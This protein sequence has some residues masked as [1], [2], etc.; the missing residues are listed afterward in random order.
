MPCTCR[1]VATPGR[2]SPVT[3]EAGALMR[4]LAVAH[5]L[6]QLAADSARQAGGVLADRLGQ[7]VGDGGV[8]S[9]GA[10]VG[11]LRE[12]SAQRERG[13]SVVGLERG[14]NRGVIGDLDDDGDIVVVFG[15]GAD[16][17]GAADV[18]VF[19]AGSSKPAPLGDGG[20]ERIEVDH[21]KVDRPDAVREHGASCSGFSRIA[22]RPPWTFGMQGFHAAVHHFGKAGDLGHV[23]DGDAGVGDRLARAAGGDEDDASR[24]K[25]AGEI[26]QARLVG[27]GKQRAL[28]DTSVGH[29]VSL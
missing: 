29:L 18:D 21:Q 10:R 28:Q 5:G 4:V 6:P 8:V 25:R 1:A 16:H 24:G 12:V 7:P 22:S 15:G 17:R 3:I 19:D 9:G 11:L 2:F 13:R 27:N 20:L 23:D 14:E 26:D